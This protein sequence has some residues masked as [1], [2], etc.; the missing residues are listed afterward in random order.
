[1][2]PRLGSGPFLPTSL[3][4]IEDRSPG[5]NEPAHDGYPGQNRRNRVTEQEGGPYCTSEG[6][7]IRDDIVDGGDEP[8]IND[9]G[10]GNDDTTRKSHGQEDAHHG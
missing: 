4:A 9:M 3:A 5:E 10:D 6:S 7:E 2:A 1:V 8:L